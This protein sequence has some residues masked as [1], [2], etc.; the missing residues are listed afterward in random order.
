MKFR[1]RWTSK[2][3]WAAAVLLCGSVPV[4]AQSS[5]ATIIFHF[6]HPA[7]APP[8]YTM[9]IHEDGSGH[10]H[11]D[12][13]GAT[14]LDQDMTLADP[15]RSQIFALVRKERFFAADCANKSKN[16]A[17]T[18]TKTLQYTGPDGNGTCT[19]D[20][21]RDVKLQ[22]AAGGLI[23]AANTM[24]QG[25]KL[26]SLLA[27]D[28]LGLDAALASLSEEQASGLAIDLQ[29]IAPVLQEIADRDEVLN[30][31]RARAASL[32]STAMPQR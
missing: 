15:L 31:S 27:H 20:H 12:A 9:V 2:L 30:H 8:S 21:A 22:E 4:L 5:Q 19:F 10:Y 17:F 11:A 23:A 18:G 6:E 28:K 25:S 16:L 32:L 13:A 24:Q 14:P 29:N 1:V 3:I 7:L 26:R